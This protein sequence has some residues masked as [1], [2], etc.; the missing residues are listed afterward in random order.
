MG[1]LPSEGRRGGVGVERLCAVAARI[2]KAAGSFV[3]AAGYDHQF[4]VVA[5]SGTDVAALRCDWSLL[6]PAKETAPIAFIEKLCGVRTAEAHPYRALAVA[7]SNAMLVRFPVEQGRPTPIL[8]LLD[9]PRSQRNANLVR[10]L[11]LDLVLMSLDL[12]PPVNPQG[13]QGFRDESVDRSLTHA[14]DALA[15]FILATLVD[16]R[17]HRTRNQIDYHTI[18]AWRSGMKTQQLD[19]LKA[20]KTLQPIKLKQKAA[21]EVAAAALSLYGRP[22]ID[23]VV[24][25]PCTHSPPGRCFSVELATQ[26]AKLLNRPLAHVLDAPRLR[27]SSHPKAGAALPFMPVTAPVK[28]TALVIDDVV[29]SG[30]HIQLAVNALRPTAKHV[31]AIGWIGD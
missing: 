19:T 15:E 29:T 20:L 8:V 18:R 28:G 7:F 6:W 21:E 5:T 27:G 22:N 12:L 14:A 2:S 9:V 11:L 30:H 16:R 17:K 25:I 26:V 4:R 1:Y 13:L 3:V 10:S 23:V 24:P 31:F